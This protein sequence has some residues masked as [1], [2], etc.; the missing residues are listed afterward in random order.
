MNS[1]SLFD[2]I[3][4]KLN[5]SYSRKVPR[6]LQT[7]SSECGL[8]CLAMVAGYYGLNVDMFNL[9]QK[10]G[11]STQGA[12][13]N[14]VAN[15]ASQIQLKTRP[16]SLGI[17]EVKQLKT[18]CILHWDMNHF[19][20]LVKVR[21]ASFVI[22]DPAFG[23]R[24]VG[25][26]EMSQHF[27][28]VALE[29]WPDKDFHKETVK[30]K[31]R[32]LD[33]MKNIDGL[34][35]ALLKIFSLSIVIESINLL[36]PVGTQLVT[37][38]VIQAHDHSLLAVICLG[39]VVF[40]L[41][42][43]FVSVIRAWTS[44]QLGTLTDIQWKTTLF[45]HLMKLPLA[46]FEKRNLGDIQSRFGSLDAIRTTF[47][48]S[49]V[50]GIIDGIMTIGLFAMMMLYGGWLVWVVFGFTACY[51]LMRLLT[52]RIYRQFSEE[53]II[54]SAK[55][56]SH[57][58][59]TLYGISTIKALGINSKRSNYWLNL[60][61]DATNTGIKITRFNML[62]GGINT[63]ITT[64][65]Q[66]IILWLGAMMVIENG[67]TLGM[68]MAFNAYR[69][70]FSQRAS[71]LIDLAINL[72]ML[73]LHNERISD[74]VFTQAEDEAEAREIFQPG[75][76][77]AVD[78]KELT[79]QYD[80]L[81][82]P[83]FADINFSIEAGESVAVVGP[84]GAGKTTLLKVMCGLLYPT[85]GRI[86]VDGIDIHKV[87][88]NNFR[89]SIACVLQ[90]DRLFS[91]SIAENICGFEANQNQ[92]LMVACA[93]YSNIHNEIMQLPMGY[94]S[95]IGELGTGISGGQKQRLFIARALYRRPSILFMDEA[96]SHLD[97][98][99]EAMINKAISSLKITRIIVAH[100]PSTIASADRVIDLNSL[101]K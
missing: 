47:T 33:L 66:V 76:G 20:V 17:D 62:F 26:K 81:S 61:V 23:R 21:H 70:Q 24:V 3:N 42:R 77:V 49:I 84:S 94:E 54:K 37:D 85:H 48:N 46:F 45:D 91:G 58:M 60:N 41:F 8:A 36:L 92:E 74:I 12:T 98:E 39:L 27:T 43:A 10:F 7:E 11:I 88:I 82:K 51:A 53:Q 68:F 32:L 44:I 15:I 2:L 75:K 95:L 56:N 72:R 34:P 9:R 4:N 28:G 50:S 67:M 31:L 1:K 52:Y 30:T 63:L 65:D 71:S 99:N 101:S 29:L 90:D 25:L 13:L 40:T 87:G 96:T 14:L 69:G 93:M 6:I 35:G 73:S 57:F 55:A 78:V 64:M 22:H 86:L 18:P 19:V 89:R 38:H 79:Y 5:F 83:I 97:L 100:R 59:E 80:A 16:L